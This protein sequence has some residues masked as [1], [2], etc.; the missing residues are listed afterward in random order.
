M[1]EGVEKPL[2]EKKPSVELA[3]AARYKKAADDINRALKDLPKLTI[4][5]NAQ[6]NELRRQFEAALRYLSKRAT[7]SLEMAERLSQSFTLIKG[8]SVTKGTFQTNAQ[9]A[10]GADRKMLSEAYALWQMRAANAV[11]ALL[12]KKAG[13]QDAANMLV[14]FGTFVAE[15][16]AEANDIKKNLIPALG[17]TPLSERNRAVCDEKAVAGAPWLLM[18]TA[19]AIVNYWK[20]PSSSSLKK[21]ADLLA[22]YAKSDVVGQYSREAVFIHENY[23]AVIRQGESAIKMVEGR[24]A[25]VTRLAKDGKLLPEDA[26]RM[27]K[28]LGIL[29]DGMQSRLNNLKSLL[30]RYSIQDAVRQEGGVLVRNPRMW[31]SFE[32]AARVFQREPIMADAVSWRALLAVA[33]YDLYATGGIGREEIKERIKELIAGGRKLVEA[34]IEYL[35]FKVQSPDGKEKAPITPNSLTAMKESKTAVLARLQRVEE[36]LFK[37]KPGDARQGVQALSAESLKAENNISKTLVKEMERWFDKRT[38]WQKYKLVV[39]DAAVVGLGITA[40]ALS[41]GLASPFVIAAEV[42]YFGTRTATDILATYVETGRRPGLFEFLGHGAMTIMPAAR[43][44]RVAVASRLAGRGALAAEF[45]FSLRL[46]GHLARRAGVEMIAETGRAARALGK[47]ASISGVYLMGSAAVGLATNPSWEN[48]LT[49][50][51]FFSAGFAGKGTA[52]MAKRTVEK[53]ASKLEEVHSA[54]LSAAEASARREARIRRVGVIA[55]ETLK[56]AGRNVREGVREAA[57]SPTMRLGI[58]D[59]IETAIKGGVEGFKKAK[60]DAGLLWNKYWDKN[61]ASDAKLLSKDPNVIF[62]AYLR[63]MDQ[64]GTLNYPDF[65]LIFKPGKHSPENLARAKAAMKWAEANLAPQPQQAALQAQPMFDREVVYNKLQ[66][67]ASSRGFDNL[68]TFFRE[69][70]PKEMRSILQNS[71]L[72]KGEIQFAMDKNF[73]PIMEHFENYVLGKKDSG[74]I[75]AI[76]QRGR[77]G[78]LGWLRTEGYPEAVAKNVLG[79]LYKSQIDAFLAKQ[80]VALTKVRNPT[81]SD[82]TGFSTNDAVRVFKQLKFGEPEITKEL[83]MRHGDGRTLSIPKNRKE[84]SIYVLGRIITDQAR[85]SLRQFFQAA[86]DANVVKEQRARVFGITPTAGTP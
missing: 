79:K 67:V 65:V 51:V 3:E 77:D 25:L 55:R 59:I 62:I 21:A 38:W 40:A 71:N 26:K 75:A 48:F 24:M 5:T 64:G 28:E 37:G 13:A 47:V 60:A 22:R 23:S 9:K 74:L 31:D 80:K 30:E 50:L 19:G 56:G 7:G 54:L 73:D 66:A 46:G 4:L 20:Q 18:Q 53:Y 72:E 41:G 86:L 84:L 32:I 85:I 78:G 49:N 29:R 36:I 6:R 12:M 81:S 14:N 11:D 17:R 15:A 43:L 16:A 69:T 45:A 61:S 27:T 10:S 34:E 70:P 35:P 83:I 44:G 2:K 33:V 76:E 57:V 58:S 52:K 39:A 68:E 42:A 1:A 82:L 63:F 8:L